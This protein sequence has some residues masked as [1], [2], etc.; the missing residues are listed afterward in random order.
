MIVTKLLECEFKD[1]GQQLSKQ[2]QRLIEDLL[3]LA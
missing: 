1:Q 3:A 2:R